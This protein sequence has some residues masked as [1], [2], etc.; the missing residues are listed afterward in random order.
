[1]KQL[2]QG[3][4]LHWAMPDALMTGEEVHSPDD[5]LAE[6]IPLMRCSISFFARPLA[7]STALEPSKWNAL[8]QSMGC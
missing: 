1:M 6:E 5:E 2:E 7:D 8:S 3:I 4:H